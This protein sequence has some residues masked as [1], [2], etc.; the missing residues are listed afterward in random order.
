MK[1]KKSAKKQ[2]PPARDVAALIERISAASDQDLVHVLQQFQSWRYP[3]GDLHA[4]IPVL[5]RS[6]SILEDIIKSY[7]LTKLQVNDFTPK[8]KELLLEVLRVQKLLLENCTNRKLFASYDRLA[9][10]LQTNDLDVLH[11]AIFVILRPAQNYQG[12]VPLEPP[13]RHTILHRLLTLSR[14]WEKL[15]GAGWDLAT[16]ASVEDINLPEALCT[17]QVQYYPTSHPSEVQE[18]TSPGRPTMSQLETPTRPRHAL[19]SQKSSSSTPMIK[20]KSSTASQ[21]GPSVVDLGNVALSFSTNYTDQLSV[22]AEEH[23]IGLEDQ[24]VALHK[25]RLVILM[26]DRPSRR[27]MLAIRFLALATYVQISSEDASQS[28]LFLYE[29]ELV[30]QLADVLRAA[31]DVGEEVATASTLALDACAHH[32]AKTGEVMTALCANV[33]HGVIISLFRKVVEHLVRGDEVS[34][35]LIDASMTLLAF[36]ASSP[37]HSNMLMGAGILAVLLDMLGTVGINRAVI[38]PRAAGLIESIIFSNPQALSNFSSMDGVNALVHRVKAEIELRLKSTLESVSEFMLEAINTMATFVHNEPTSLAILQEMQLPQVFYAQLESG[39]PPSYEVISSACNA[40]GAVCLNPAG[41]D[42][43]LAHPK[44]ITNLVNTIMSTTHEY[45]FNERD[46]ARH[47]GSLLDELARHHPALRPVILQA[48]LGLLRQATDAGI[49]FEPEESQRREYF[50]DEM[51][52]NSNPPIDDVQR[53]Q[54]PPSNTCLST[55]SRVLSGLLRNAAIAKDFI[56]NGGLD[57]L[58]G[59]ADLPCLPIRFGA[60]DAANSL[61]HLLKHIGEHSHIQLIDSIVASIQE[62][63]NRCIG[64]WKDDAAPSR[65]DAMHAGTADDDVRKQFKTLRSLAVRLTFLSEALFALSFSH[66]RIATSIIKALGVTTGS[67]FLEDLGQ[68]HRVCFQHHVTLRT[69]KS[70]VS[71]SAAGWLENEEIAAAPTPNTSDDPTK[72]SG[73]KYLATRLHAVLA[74][75]FRGTHDASA[76]MGIDTVALGLVIMLLFD[77]RGTDGHLNTTLFLSFERNGGFDRILVTSKRI[78]SQLDVSTAVEANNRDQAQKDAYIAAMSGLKIVLH[79]LCAFVSAKSLLENPETHAIEQRQPGRKEPV[80]SSTKLFVKLRLAVFPVAQH[81]WE[82]TWLLESP[83][84]ILKLAVRCFSMVMAGKHESPIEAE[85]SNAGPPIVA[86]QPRPSPVTADPARVNQLVDMGFP[87]GAAERALL[88]TRNNVTA[89]TDLILSMPH[90]F[91]DEP[92]AN[93]PPHPQPSPGDVNASPPTVNAMDDQ[94]VAEP[95]SEVARMEPDPTPEV[96]EETF[97]QAQAELTKLRDDFR[98]Q[99]PSRALSLLDHAEDLVFD[100]LPCFPSGEQGVTY[101]LERLLDVSSSYEASRDGAISA[102]LRLLAL[103]LRLG[104]GVVLDESMLSKAAEVLANLPMENEPRARWLSALFLFAESIFASSTAVTKVKIGDDPELPVTRHA[105]SL[106]T[107]DNRLSAVSTKLVAAQDASREELMGGLRLLALLSRQSE[108]TTN[109]TEKA[110]DALKSFKDPSDKLAGC[111]PLLVMIVRH[112]F[113][114]PDTLTDIMQGEIRQWLSPTRNK[115]TDIQHFVRQ[116]RPAALRQPTCFVRA[117]EQECALVDSTPPQSVYHIRSRDENKDTPAAPPSTD[118]FRE[119]GDAYSSHPVIDHILLELSDAVRVCVGTAEHSSALPPTQESQT[120]ALSYSGLLM[121]LLTELLGSYAHAKKAFMASLRNGRL[122]VSNRSRGNISTLI[123]DLIC[124]VG[125][126]PDLSPDTDQSSSSVRRVAISSWASSVVV[127]LCS[128]ITPI[129]GQKDTSEFM[130]SVRK[131]VLDAILKGIRETTAILDLSVRYGRLW[132]LGQLIYRLLMARPTAP[133]RQGNDSGLHM[134][135]TMLEKNFVGVMTTA[136]GEIDLNYPGVRIVLVTLLRALEH[137]SKLS[138]KWGKASKESQEASKNRPIDDEESASTSATESDLDVDMIEEDQAAPDLYRNSALGMIGGELGDEDE[139]DD[140]DEDEEDDDM[141]SD[142]ENS[143]TNKFKDMGDDLSDGEDGTDTDTS[144]DE[145]MASHMD[146]DDWTDELADGDEDTEGDEYMDQEVLLGSGENEDAEIWEDVPDDHESFTS[147]GQED[148]DDNEIHAEG[149]FGD[150]GDHDDMDMEDEAEEFDQIEMLESFPNATQSNGFGRQSP[151]LA[152]PW[153]WDQPGNRSSQGSADRR[154]QSILSEHN[155]AVSLFGAPQPRSS[156]NLAQHPLVTNPSSQPAIARGLPR[157]FGNNYNDLMSAIE[158]MGG[159]DAVQMLET[160]I[161]SRQLAGSDAIRI[162]VAQDQTGIIGLSVGGRTFAFNAATQRLPTGASSAPTPHTAHAPLTTLDRWQVEMNLCTVARNESASRLVVHLINR[163]MPEARHR[164]QEEEARIK[165]ADADAA[166]AEAE[167]ETKG[168]SDGI[169][170]S[171]A[172]A[173]S[174]PSPSPIRQTVDDD[175]PMHDTGDEIDQSEAQVA[176]AD[177]N[178]TESLARTIISIHGQ[179]VDITD[180]G[181]DLEFLQALPDDM[182]ADVVEQYLGEQNRQRR[183]APDTVP[184]TALQINSE[185]LDALPPDIRAEVIMQ[186]AM[187]TARR[188]QPQAQTA[189]VGAP[190]LLGGPTGFLSNLTDELRDV[191]L[192]GQPHNARIAAPPRGFL[193][194]PPLE[195]QAESSQ[196]A[197]KPHREA[198]QLLDKPGIASLVRL[199]FFPQTLKKGHLFKVMVNLCENTN[200]RTDLLNLLLSVVQ[201]GSGDLLAVDRSFQQ[202]SLRGVST[203]RATPKGKNVDS[204]ATVVLP[205]GLFGHLQTEHVPTFIAQRCFEALVYIV[206]SNNNA[207]SYFL[208]EHE[209]PVGLRKHTSRKGKGKEKMLPQTKFPIVVLL[210]LL[211]RPLLAKTPGMMETV[212]SLL[213][214]ITRPLLEFKSQTAVSPSSLQGES[215]PHEGNADIATNQIANEDNDVATNTESPQSDNQKSK[216]ST[217][218]IPPPVL[219]LIVNCLTSGD[220]T[221]ATFSQTLVVMQ[222]LACLPDARDVILLELRARCHDLGATVQEQLAELASTLKDKTADVGPLTLAKF[223]P[224]TSAQAQLLRLLKTIDYLHLNKVDSDAPMD[225]MTDEERAVSVIFETFDFDTLWTHLGDCL[226]LIETRETSD[227]IA[228]VL[229]P[230]V[231]GLMVVSKYRSRTQRE[232]RSP[233]LNAPGADNSDLFVSFTTAH[234]KVLNTIVRNNP[235]LLSGSFSL[236]IRNPRVLEFDNKRNWFFQK[237]KRKRD[238]TVV[239]SV[240]HLNIRR[241]YV[242][243]DSFRALQRKTGDEIK[244]GKLSVKFHHEDG[245]DAGGVTREWYSVLAQQIF[246]PNFALFEPCAADKQ[247]YQPNKASSVNDEHLSYFKFVGRVIGK[248]VYDGRLL[249]AYF[250]RAFYKQ[251]LGRTV[252]MRDLESIDPEYHKSLQWMLDNDITGV[253]DQE[254]TTEDDQF[255]EKKIV[256]LKELG[257]RIPVTEENKDEYVRLVVSYRLDNSI[258]DQIKAFLEGFYEIIP[259]EIIQIFEPD[260]LELLISGITTV[261]V[262]ELKNATQMSGWKPT[263]PEISWFWRALRSFS[264][265]ERSRFL[266]FVTSSSRVPLGGFTQLQGSSGTQPFQIQKLYA[267]EGSL[268]QASTCF[269]LLL[270]PTYASYEQLRERLQFAITETGGFGKA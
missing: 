117:V 97:V 43:T 12:H 125:L 216:K 257:A 169:T 235:S 127:A 193:G 124:C 159:S 259:P 148:D 207:V 167:A 31:S 9:D 8:T 33:N 86:H 194:G 94:P 60:T 229:L 93:E 150:D 38:I 110:I 247:T 266:M 137:L 156:M 225:E 74:K 77:G 200:T 202:M 209:Q 112:A 158:D 59:I 176:S 210:G 1:V 250:N 111:H 89:A 219:R 215:I 191:M 20:S 104:E 29:P 6:D 154:Q 192:L 128:D 70:G 270:L 267:K 7:D 133:N 64:L 32:R 179:D 208:T 249:D 269:N 114:D 129:I 198:I 189:A 73:A 100:L 121:S 45:V 157:S 251:I 76:S 248:A 246:D 177:E 58:L 36:I 149:F 56:T 113:E 195:A 27:R 44:V 48:S 14:G 84:P 115:V 265:E 69:T 244:Y 85:S 224:P 52:Q 40:I 80:F 264:Q 155:A 241:Q 162:E 183:P 147:D 254:F 3:R 160:L 65:W 237:L 166:K 15:I 135:K 98:P 256:E 55:F 4:W 131:T 28:G 101:L 78:V 226:T 234:R 22:L 184:E 96:L 227:Q 182:R 83:M 231:E 91:H 34:F 190:S 2:I 51:A 46:N 105:T 168:K 236:L 188:N 151:D 134:A 103:Y 253:I 49:A 230:L 26:G 239:P 263:D 17:V 138:V 261:D 255:G 245:V 47:L 218:V 240:L 71:D 99:L 126:Q 214:T 82:A 25:L 180:T 50:L 145:S 13:L 175:V 10:L 213:A 120:H 75:F 92:L 199:L 90:V 107:L 171:A 11:S 42:H 258:K 68:I 165:Q 67:T 87:R 205:I 252:D 152:G 95:A 260:Q 132:S 24:Y 62:A 232:T 116:L 222:N 106:A 164:A 16:L 153:G 102:R 81:I 53:S 23:H 212:T 228:M 18:E 173:E 54:S 161:A 221:R 186:E 61:A 197:S 223:S 37:M 262:D 30:T 163:L 39:V 242:F 118:P 220:C 136:L 185:F 109:H 238:A 21:A 201:D 142:L 66:A 122:V 203:P 63:M 172:L 19:Q 178:V 139:D 143:M 5:D 141:V 174:H 123:N 79:I 187:E 206:N 140:G 57:L 211:E 119:T 146:N 72:E 130:V 35:E 217:P 243:E 196:A 233:S 181:I 268:P 170:A 144:D 204:P 88:R 41:L 108:S